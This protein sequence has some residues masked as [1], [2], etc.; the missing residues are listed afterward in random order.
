MKK[1]WLKAVVVGMAII[2]GGR[3]SYADDPLYVCEALC[4]TNGDGLSI[5]EV[6][7]NTNGDGSSDYAGQTINCAGGIV[8]AK[9][10]GYRHRI[11]LQDPANANGW[12]GIQVQDQTSDNAFDGVVLGDWVKLTN[13]LIEEV[14]SRGTTMLYYE[15]YVSSFQVTTN[16][17]PLPPAII[18]SVSDIP[19]PISTNGGWFVENHDAE[20]YESM[21]LIVRDV[22]VTQMGLG[23]APDNYNLQTSEGDDCWA[24]DYMNEDKEYNP[25]YEE[26]YHPF[27]AVGQGFCAVA[28]VFEQYTKL[29]SNWDYY[30][31]VTT[32]TVD[33]AICGD[34]NNDGDVQ[35]DDLPRFA[36]CM[37]GPMC[38]SQPDGCD[39]PAW[40][41]G[42][43]NL[44]LQ[45]CLMMDQDYDGDVDLFDFVELQSVLGA[46]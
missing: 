4:N 38:D 8:V 7:C 24:T 15:E 39:P 42:P 3:V 9:Y 23:K 10:D 32:K 43:F 19:A 37:T 18:V 29:S 31:L 2:S 36:E 14:N 35:L 20:L 16:G 30:Q 46:P 28:G 45:H 41:E 25:E 40:T 5:C 17:L 27:V 22:A 44:H 26:D 1:Y 13:V 33:L 12:G 34:G 11:I 21:R 6:Q